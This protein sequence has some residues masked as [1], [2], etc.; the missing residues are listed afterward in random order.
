[1]SYHSNSLSSNWYQYA[2]NSPLENR[3][4]GFFLCVFLS[5]AKK[6]IPQ[7]YQSWKNSATTDLVEIDKSEKICISYSVCIQ[8][9]VSNKENQINFEN[10]TY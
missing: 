2:T 3:I 1:M 8:I 7:V 10:T 6:K 9:A 5:W 4:L